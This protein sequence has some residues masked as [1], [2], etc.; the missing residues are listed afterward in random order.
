MDTRLATRLP[1]AV[2]VHAVRVGCGARPRALRRDESAGPGYVVER[3]SVDFD[4]P[5]ARV[6]VDVVAA[7][8]EDLVVRA[9]FPVAEVAPDDPQARLDLE[10]AGAG[11]CMVAWSSATVARVIV[12]PPE[13][14]WRQGEVVV[15][16]GSG[17]FVLR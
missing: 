17:T 12:R 4:G 3:G 10:R 2:V 15:G 9:P 13:A 6:L 1:E 16:V 14:V 7:A 8:G 5:V 11:W